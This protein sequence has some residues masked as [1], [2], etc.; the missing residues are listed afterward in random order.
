MDVNNEICALAEN[1]KGLSPQSR[2]A[3]P[4][5]IAKG[6]LL[7]VWGISLCF[8]KKKKEKKAAKKKMSYEETS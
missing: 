5:A 1:N 2:I 8:G 6:R 4:Q 3:R 7:G